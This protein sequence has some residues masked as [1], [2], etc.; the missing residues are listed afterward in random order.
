MLLHKVDVTLGDQQAKVVDP[1]LDGNPNDESAMWRPQETYLDQTNQVI[2]HVE[3]WT[4][5]TAT[6]SLSNRALATVYVE[7]GASEPGYGTQVSPWNT[8]EE[9]YA[10]VF[11]GGVVYLAPGTYA[12]SFRIGKRCILR[13]SGSSGVVRIGN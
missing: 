5:T 13:R 7:D 11:D 2:I 4:P 3:D 12:E 8:V 6:V 1:D 10:S 9:G